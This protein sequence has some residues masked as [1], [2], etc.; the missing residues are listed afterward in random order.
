MSN[1]SK[2]FKL[3]EQNATLKNIKSLRINKLTY[4]ES[5]FSF[6]EGYFLT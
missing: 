2:V 5:P 6:S 4:Y 1:C 3:F